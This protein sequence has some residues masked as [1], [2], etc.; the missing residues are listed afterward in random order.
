MPDLARQLDAIMRKPADFAT[1]VDKT[2][3]KMV[4]YSLKPL[5]GV[6]LAV[7]VGV[8]GQQ[9]AWRFGLEGI[10]CDRIDELGIEVVELQRGDGRPLSPS[11][12]RIK[13]GPLE[14]DLVKVF[15]GERA[16]F[17]NVMP[18]TPPYWEHQGEKTPR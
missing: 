1:S 6:E 5:D 17:C 16:G 4:T 10:R 13:G 15:P 9:K 18:G 8:R 2:G 11:W 7:F 12:Y 3:T 14:G